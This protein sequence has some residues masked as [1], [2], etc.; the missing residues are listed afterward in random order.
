[1]PLVL[2][3]SMTMSWCFSNETTTY[4]QSI[5]TALMGSY[6]EVPGASQ[7]TDELALLS[8]TCRYGPHCLRRRVSGTG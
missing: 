3:A 1:M 6:A 7:P 2:D 4:S 8:L 5:L